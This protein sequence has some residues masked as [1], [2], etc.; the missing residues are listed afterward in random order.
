MLPFALFIGLWD[1]VHVGVRTVWV[2]PSDLRARRL[3]PIFA[4]TRTGRFVVE[5]LDRENAAYRLVDE[6]YAAIRLAR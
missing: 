5:Q 4:V 3:K 1:Q 6:F 2:L